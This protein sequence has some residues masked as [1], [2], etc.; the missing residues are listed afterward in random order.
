MRLRDWLNNRTGYRK[1]LDH[2]LNEPVLGGARWAYIFGSALAILFCIQILTGIVLAFY[3]SPS[4]KEAW[5]SVYYLDQEILL[6]WFVRGLHHYSSSAIIL[7]LVTHLF[8]VFLYGAYRPPRELT[9]WSG[10]L[11]LFVTLAFSL[12]GY[13]LPWDQKGFWATSVVASIAGTFPVIGHFLRTTLQGGNDFGNLT[14]TRF[15]G[16]HVFL[17]PAFLTSLFL[18]HLFLFRRNGVTP[19][20]KRDT[21]ELHKKTEPFWPKQIIYDIIFATAL[22]FVLSLFVIVQHGAPLDAPADPSSSYLARPEWYF[23]W[24]FELLKI[25]PGKWEGPA[26]LGFCLFTFF[27]LAALPLVEKSPVPS[28]KNR[29]VHL[30]VAFGIAGLISWLTL[31]SFIADWNDKGVALQEKQAQTETAKALQLAKGGIPP[32]GALDLYLNDSYETG[33]RL[34]MEHCKNCHKAGGEEEGEGSAPDLTNFMTHEWVKGLIAD[35]TDPKYFGK[36]KIT[37]MDPTDVPDE[38]LDALT[39]YVLS[40]G[41]LAPHSKRGETL[42]EDSGCHTCHPRGNEE[43]SDGPTLDQYGSK[44]WMYRVIKN[45]DHPLLYGEQNEMPAFDGKLLD[46]QIDDLINYIFNKKSLVVSEQL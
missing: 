18:F 21:N 13:L 12:T 2:L 39:D 16:F 43:A 29:R 24:L 38:D 42:F 34:F 27:F 9:W 17:L 22:V 26:V 33:K 28:F 46:S 3:Y 14:L 20:W 41:G 10:I 1:L 45:P 7:L 4:T 32:G 6:G 19:H 15:F 40:L 44:T 23:R 25:V 37:G 5:G 36:T 31:S 11:M 35:P 30:V 8:Q